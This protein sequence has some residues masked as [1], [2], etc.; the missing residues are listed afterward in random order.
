MGLARSL[1]KACAFR[2][3]CLYINNL[4]LEGLPP[5]SWCPVSWGPKINLHAYSC[6]HSLEP[7]IAEM[8][9]EVEL[10]SLAS[11]SLDQL[12]HSQSCRFVSTRLN[13]CCSE[14]LSFGG[15]L[16]CSLIEVRADCYTG[17]TAKQTLLSPYWLKGEFWLLLHNRYARTIQRCYDENLG[18]K[19]I[20]ST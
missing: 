2:L 13:P 3:L 14:P 19:I 7:R 1:K 10:P 4:P 6:I 18:R 5:G 17:L 8:Q 15:G 20:Q 11:P 9:P 16:L 12:N